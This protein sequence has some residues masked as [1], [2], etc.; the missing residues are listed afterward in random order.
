MAITIDYTPMGAVGKAAIMAGQGQAAAEQQARSLELYRIRSQQQYG[1]EMMRMQTQAA[2]LSRQEQF[3]YNRA[4]FMQKA[5]VDMQMEV[6]DYARKK[7]KLNAVLDQ[8]NESDE[9][10]AQQKE[11]LAI[12]AMAKYADVGRGITDLQGEAGG[13]T[14][15][16]QTTLQKGQYFTQVYNAAMEAVRSGQATLPQAQQQMRAIGAPES[17]VKQMD[18]QEVME[19]EAKK[20]IIEL[21]RVRD[22]MMKEFVVRRGTV[23]QVLRKKPGGRMELSKLKEGSPEFNR[24]QTLLTEQQRLTENLRDLQS[25]SDFEQAMSID[26]NLQQAVA[27]AGY[28]AVY[29]YWMMKKTQTQA[30]QEEEAG[31]VNWIKGGKLW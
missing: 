19:N 17:M 4:L 1:M 24:Y 8:I 13:M 29:K 23:H 12:Q 27:E 7:Q 11:T 14:A 26:E 25:R 20:R 18:R 22:V 10:T 9:F 2:Q 3:E 28:E 5:Q 15:G 6:A 16:M 31:F 21:Q 30:P